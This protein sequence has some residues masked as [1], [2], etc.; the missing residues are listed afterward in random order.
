MND[1]FS[2]GTPT[3]YVDW[4]EIS[5]FHVS[6]ENIWSLGVGLE[7]P[8]NRNALQWGATR[9]ATPKNVFSVQAYKMT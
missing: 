3:K 4:D 2:L 5:I 8:L 1:I 9:P 7:V 6:A